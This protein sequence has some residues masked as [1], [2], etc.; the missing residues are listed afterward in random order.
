MSYKTLCKAAEYFEDRARRAR[1]PSNQERLTTVAKKYR[2]RAEVQ[3]K[4]ETQSDH[5]GKGPGITSR[6]G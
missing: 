1:Q 3:R 5:Q 6:P 2:L 4:R